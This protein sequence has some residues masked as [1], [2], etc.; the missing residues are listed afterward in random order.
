MA[1]DEKDP[2]TGGR[3]ALDNIAAE[4]ISELRRE[5]FGHPLDQRSGLLHR[6]G[7]LE[8]GQEEMKE[9]LSSVKSDVQSLKAGGKVLAVVLSL[10]I[11]TLTTLGV[12]LV[13][14]SHP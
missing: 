6:V 10:L 12:A 5:V 9:D 11:P 3:R 1:D 8:E 7:G 13:V 14:G 4:V 2:V